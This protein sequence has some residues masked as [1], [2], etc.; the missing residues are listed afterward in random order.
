MCFRWEDVI[1][2]IVERVDSTFTVF[3]KHDQHESNEFL[4][5]LL[6]PKHGAVFEFLVV[7]HDRDERVDELWRLAE[8][9]QFGLVLI[10]QV[11]EFKT[12]ACHASLYVCLD[13]LD[14]TFAEFVLQ[15][16]AG[17]SF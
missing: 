16:R 8:V 12:I 15:E 4:L 3:H 17:V 9:L 5:R 1:P 14:E 13:F 6:A 2:H 10:E 11:H 7:D